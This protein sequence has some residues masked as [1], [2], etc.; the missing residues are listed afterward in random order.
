MIIVYDEYGA[1][2]DHVSPPKLPD[3]RWRAD[4]FG[5]GSR[6]PAILISPLARKGV[7][8]STPYDTT[9]ILKLL[10]DHFHLDPL[11]SCRVNA[12]NSMAKLF[13]P[14]ANLAHFQKSAVPDSQSEPPAFCK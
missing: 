7:V 9:A 12:Q 14:G 2:W 10:Q 4:T 3:V 11:P 5:P 13:S 1:F 8:D 6:V